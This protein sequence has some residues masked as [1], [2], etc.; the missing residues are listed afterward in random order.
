MRA[1]PLKTGK[2]VQKMRTKEPWKQKKRNSRANQPAMAIK[3]PLPRQSIKH[4][5]MERKDLLYH[6][7]EHTSAHKLLL[8]L[9]EL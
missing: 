7:E 5:N 2:K 6:Q 1:S 4:L 3:H 9:L 8:L